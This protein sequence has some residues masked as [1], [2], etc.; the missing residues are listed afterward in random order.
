MIE[1]DVIHVDPEQ[2]DRQAIERAA[3]MLREGRLVAFPT[4]TVYG[5]GVHALDRD[6][7]RRLFDAKGRP[8][9]D[10][11]IVHIASLEGL[12]ALVGDVPDIARVLSMMCPACAVSR[13]G[14]RVVSRI[15][16]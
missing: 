9:D 8:A 14:A 15:V 6:A 4:E 5:L 10:P 3:R 12:P 1:T 2:P 16:L 7:V 13:M 11:L